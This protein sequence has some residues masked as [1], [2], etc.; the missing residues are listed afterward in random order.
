MSLIRRLVAPVARPG[1][2]RLATEAKQG[3]AAAEEAATPKKKASSNPLTGPVGAFGVLGGIWYF[4]YNKG[5]PPSGMRH[6]SVTS[7]VIHKNV[8]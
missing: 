5:N 2:R 6:T 7:S 3:A 8:F 1:F 4:F